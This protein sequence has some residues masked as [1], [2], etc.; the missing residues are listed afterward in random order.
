MLNTDACDHDGNTLIH[1]AV[2]M[3]KVDIIQVLYER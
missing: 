2:A 3:Q 1:Y